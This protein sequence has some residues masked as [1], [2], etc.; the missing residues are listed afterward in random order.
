M[1]TQNT[2]ALKAYGL[3]RGGI[4]NMFPLPITALRDPGTQDFAQPMTF[5]RNI[6][7]PAVPRVFVFAGSNNGAAIWQLIEAAGGAGVFANLTVN[8]GPTNLTGVLTQ[9]GTANINNTGAANTLIGAV[10]NTGI[11]AIGNS[12]SAAVSVVGP[13]SINASGALNTNIGAT[14]NTGSVF[15]GNELSTGVVIDGLTTI[16]NG[17]ALDTDIGIGGTGA[18]HM[19]NATGNTFVDAGSLQ[20]TAGNLILAALGS[21]LSITSAVNGVNASVGVTAAM[22]AGSVIVANTAVTANSLILV[23]H[24]VAAGTLG[25]LSIGAVVPG[26]S[27][28]VLTDN[29]LDTSTVTFLMIN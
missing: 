20:I 6:V 21:K 16:N 15:I 3:N 29:V 10:T 12:L 25:H 24:G 4:I 23:S 27:F 2:G 22:A 7:A 19:G 9:L 8:P 28:Q 26:V 5:W 14:N 13:V 1:P 17:T 18:V 11:V